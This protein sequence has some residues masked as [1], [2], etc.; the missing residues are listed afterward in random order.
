MYGPA[1][2][3]GD[4]ARELP[5]RIGINA[6]FLEPGMGGLDTYV[7]ELMP[8][9]LRAAP[10]IRFTIFC[11]SA[12][13]RYLRSNS[14]TEDVKFFTHP[15]FGT[16]GLKAITE[17]TVLGAYASRR[18]E[19]LHSVALTAPFRTKAVN[20]VTIADVIWMLDRHPDMT[21]RLWR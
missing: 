8:E 10:Q 11:S 18:V 14:W 9:L 6:I 13:E 15:A 1:A 2:M 21:T 12:A 3:P 16:R 20:V 4:D 17:L 7:R 19:L 5:S